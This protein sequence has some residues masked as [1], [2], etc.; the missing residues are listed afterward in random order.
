MIPAWLEGWLLRLIGVPAAQ[1][2][3]VDVCRTALEG[4]APVSV[5]DLG[6]GSGVYAGLLPFERYTGVDRSRQCIESARSHCRH[7]G[8][9]FQCADVSAFL[10][11]DKG[12]Y[13]LVLM[14]G[15]LHHL[16]DSTG[17]AVLEASARLLTQG[18]VAVSVDPVLLPRQRPMAR[19]MALLDRGNHVRTREGYGAL[20]PDALRIHEQRVSGSELRVP[21]DLLLM[22]MRRA[23]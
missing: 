22:V 1:S 3:L 4:R 7:S 20:V 5:L 19:L 16:D 2:R 8:A 23:W 11:D 13:D 6:C 10:A 9:S 18:G 14:V 15:L 17:R 21:Q 12:P